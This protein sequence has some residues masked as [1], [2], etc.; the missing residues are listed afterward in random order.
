MAVRHRSIALP[1]LVLMLL[2]AHPPTVRAD[3]PSE[4]SILD[5]PNSEPVPTDNTP[6]DVTCTSAEDCWVVGSF[7]NGG[8]D[9]TLIERWDGTAWSL[10][11]SPNTSAT[12]R[13][14]LRDVACSSA[15]DC[16]A[17]GSF[18]NGDAEQTLI[19]RWDG[20][21]WTIAASPNTSATQSNFLTGVACPSPTLCWA[22]GS[23]VNGNGSY[24]ALIERWDGSAWTIVAAPNT[25]ATQSNFLNDLTCSSTTSC[26]AVGS[27]SSSVAEQTLIQRWDGT[28]WT[29]AT[30][31]NTGAGHNILY[32]VTCA[33]ASDCWAVGS[34]VAGNIQQ[35]LIQRWNGTLWTS[36]LSPNTSPTPRSNVLLGVACASASSCWAIGRAEITSEDTDA[37]I[38]RWDGTA[39]TVAAPPTVAGSHQLAGATCVSM[40][41]CWTVGAA[42]VDGVQQVLTERWNATAWSIVP[43]ANAGTPTHNTLL[44]VT[45]VTASDCWSVASY[46]NGSVQQTLIQRWNGITWGI[47]PSPNTSSTSS[48]IL[49]DVA[50]GSSSDCWAVGYAEGVSAFQTLTLHWDGSMWSIVASP[51]TAAV[52]NNFLND[53]T[54]VSSTECWAVGFY[55]PGSPYQTL[56]ERWDG[57]AWTIVASPNTDL[58][59]DN[60]LYGVTCAMAGECWAVGRYTVPPGI[61]QNL[62]QRW[63]GNAWTIADAPNTSDAQANN[64]WSVA[65]ASASDCWA[66]GSYS[67]GSG[68]AHTL[69]E[70]WDGA[71]WTIAPSPDPTALPSNY[72]FLRSVSC[73][74]ASACWAVGYYFE[75]GHNRSLVER[76]DGT[77]WSIVTTPNTSATQSNYLIGV[78]CPSEIACLASGYHT[79]DSGIFRTLTQRFGAT[80]PPNLPP[81]A[82]VTANVT[83]GAAPLSV[84][85]DASTS[86]D[87]DAGDQVAGYTF[88]FGD[89]APAVTQP[90]ASITHTYT[91][92]GIYDATVSVTDTHGASSTQ[93]A[94]VSIQV[95]LGNTAITAPAADAA[96]QTSTVTVSGVTGENLTV[97]LIEDATVLET[98]LSDAAGA[99][100]FTHTFPDGAHTIQIDVTDAGGNPA[101]ASATR[102]FTVD[103]T[104]PGVPEVASPTEGSTL[105]GSFVTFTGGSEP[106]ALV[107]LRADARIIAAV[108]AND[109]GEWLARAGFRN[110][111]HTVTAAAMDA[112]GN[113]SA[114]VMRAFTVADTTPPL[115]P[116]ISSPTPSAS[117]AGPL[118]IV[119]GS[120][121]PGSLIELREG[122]AILG[123]TPADASGAWHRALAE[124][125]AGAHTISAT[126]TDPAGNTGPASGEHSFSVHLDQGPVLQILT[127]APNAVV[128]GD[129][130]VAG[131]N[132]PAGAPVSLLE[133]GKHLGTVTARSDGTWSM[134]LRM[135]G[136]IHTI[137]ATSPA[138]TASETRTFTVD[139]EPP[140]V[141][142][143]TAPRSLFLPDQPVSIDGAAADN[144]S[145]VSVT[146][147]Y[148][149]AR[150]RPVATQQA[151][152]ACAPGV[153]SVAWTASPTLPSGYYTAVARGI[154]EAGNLSASSSMTFIRL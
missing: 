33:G 8:T 123:V 42:V 106:G 141:S 119:T 57:N 93:A 10:V 29:I 152:C 99:F 68:T 126:A 87:P 73:A 86:R 31:P 151:T 138:A 113:T 109:A 104:A 41:E 74:T 135:P 56:I 133:D 142:V 130:I 62:I 61:T 50:C 38:E 60:R 26:W 32:G 16:W 4:W 59:H 88:D 24:Q 52:Q 25:S 1:L 147:T 6:S 110:G 121:E 107:T 3:A 103:T 9:Q 89:G 124:V 105:S 122:S 14:A 48:N 120:A 34:F 136:G 125:P 154:D 13:N 96:L 19:L 148:L 145:V 100:S 40:G 149:D 127:P 11:A 144:L 53:V 49:Y 112:V 21:S 115:T 44:G 75:G 7:R 47:V 63:D 101:A 140:N 139:A 17:V 70:R 2:G 22:A 77:A 150:G 116:V 36:I 69:I 72:I 131:S 51:S 23:A 71:S 92:A 153:R 83:A 85:L 111:T 28:S 79:D 114:A 80:T 43:A 102:T 46:H 20:S 18:N 67:Q 78:S 30:S 98:T 137:V 95:A 76:W 129:T 12:Q 54:C 94:S 117:V 143:S 132:A 45:C 128:P 5:S 90:Q 66:V 91:A 65:C 134:G 118:V 108:R 27:A 82:H 39:W 55:D 35:T 146:V 37:L 81:V 64:L 97:R 84:T 15:S 58:G